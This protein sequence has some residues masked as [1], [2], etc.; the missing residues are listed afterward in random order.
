MCAYSWVP[1][2]L[3]KEEVE[4][5][6][7]DWIDF[8]SQEIRLGTEAESKNEILR[9][10]ITCF[11]CEEKQWQDSPIVLFLFSNRDFYLNIFSGSNR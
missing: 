11:H 7:W 2:R 9:V 6:W 1:N 3:R 10:K 8:D 5:R 4:E